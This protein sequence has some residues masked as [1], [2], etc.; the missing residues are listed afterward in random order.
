MD[1]N[2][3]LNLGQHRME[4][5]ITQDANT[6]TQIGDAQMNS[7]PFSILPGLA[8]IISTTAKAQKTEMNNYTAIIGTNAFILGGGANR[9]RCNGPVC[10]E[11][12]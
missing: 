4:Q 5:W 1:G 7:Y 8:W 9:S 11:Y 3:R 6:D 10:A 12:D 2:S